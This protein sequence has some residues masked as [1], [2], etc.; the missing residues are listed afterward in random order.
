MQLKRVQL[1]LCI[2][3]LFEMAVMPALADAPYEQYHVIYDD[4]A[5]GVLENTIGILTISSGVKKGEGFQTYLQ[6]DGKF[7]PHLMLQVKRE[8]RPISH[9]GYAQSADPSV[10]NYRFPVI[11]RQEHFVCLIYDPVKNLQA[12]INLQELTG[13]F[14]YTLVMFDS[15]AAKLNSYEFVDI[16]P[17]T[18]NGKRKLYQQPQPDARFTIISK[19]DLRY[20]QLKVVAQKDGYLQVGALSQINE[21]EAKI[22]PIGWIRIRDDERRLM[23]WIVAVDNC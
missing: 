6:N 22:N 17:F 10:S 20:R 19:D 4:I 3:A 18:K 12:W 2:I 13:N 1:P 9:F 14:Y 8:T 11:K 16:F 7:T 23:I 21:K 15:L 5:N